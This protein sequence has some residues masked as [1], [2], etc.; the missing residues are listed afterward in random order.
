MEEFLEKPYSIRQFIVVEQDEI[1]ATKLKV[2]EELASEQQDK[3][4]A[5]NIEEVKQEAIKKAFDVQDVVSSHDAG[6]TIFTA[7]EK[8]DEDKVR[9]V[10][11]DAGYEVTG[12]TQE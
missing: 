3:I 8:V 11:K 12:I 6:T 2:Q 10:I 5:G 1:I 7:S 9:K 4:A